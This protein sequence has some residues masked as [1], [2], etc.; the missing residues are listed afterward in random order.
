[1]SEL[2]AAN[3]PERCCLCGSAEDLTGEH[4]VKASTIRSLF[5]GEPMMIGSFDGESRPRLA[6]SSKSKAFHFQ[7]KVCGTCNSTRT[8]AADVEFARFDEAARALLA[9][10]R[11][12]LGVLDD[13]GYAVGSDPYVNVFRYLAKVL[14]CQIAEVGGPRISALVLRR[15]DYDSLREG[16][17]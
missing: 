15:S 1:M 2:F 7:S 11:D 3:Y 13:P 14:A 5:S 10:G 16:V 17:G 4:K 6:Q 9:Q 12:P 8:Q